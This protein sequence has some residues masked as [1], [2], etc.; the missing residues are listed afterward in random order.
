MNTRGSGS[1]SDH[2]KAVVDFIGGVTIANSGLAFHI[3]AF[4]DDIQS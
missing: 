1:F 3:S 2:F 4:R